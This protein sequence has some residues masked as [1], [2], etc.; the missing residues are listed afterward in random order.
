MTAERARL[1]WRCR[2]GT[3]ELDCLLGGYLAQGYDAAPGDEKA[4]FA[5]L[6]ELPDD[7]LTRLLCGSEPSPDPVL[8]S[9]VAKIRAL[10]AP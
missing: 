5:R 10:A 9:L 2:R 7:I 1:I 6:L 3:K 8:A 4:A